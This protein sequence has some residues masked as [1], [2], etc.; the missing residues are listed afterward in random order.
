MNLDDDA[1]MDDATFRKKWDTA[2]KGQIVAA[3]VTKSG[4]I[5]GPEQEVNY[6][7]DTFLPVFPII[8]ILNPFFLHKGCQC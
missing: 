4:V 8:R 1:S 2:R 6:I 5:N 3:A 7:G